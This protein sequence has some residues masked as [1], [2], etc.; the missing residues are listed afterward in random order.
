MQANFSNNF[1]NIILI[2]MA[3]VGKSTAGHVLAR[4]CGKKFIDTDELITEQVGMEL[5]EYLDRV[6]ICLLYTSPS[7]RD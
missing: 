2:G 4:I 6:G 7:P 5:Q 1:S 3:G